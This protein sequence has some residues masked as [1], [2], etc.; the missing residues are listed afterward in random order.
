MTPGP[1]TDGVA[2]AKWRH[3]LKN[4]IG[5]VL[6]YSELVLQDLEPTNPMR[7]DIEE[8]FK[9]AQQAMVLLAQIEPE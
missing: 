5:I 4:Q 1:V 6:G 2:S 9:A 8:I 7:G 3:D